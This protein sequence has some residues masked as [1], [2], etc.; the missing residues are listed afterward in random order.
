MF[1]RQ[2]SIGQWNAIEHLG[3]KEH[4]FYSYGYCIKKG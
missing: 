4:F 3:L 1:R 2:A